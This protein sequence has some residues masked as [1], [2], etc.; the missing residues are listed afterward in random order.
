MVNISRKIVVSGLVQG[1]WFRSFVVDSARNLSIKGW[2]RN[3][4]DGQVELL[5]RGSPENVDLLEQALWIGSPLSQVSDVHSRQSKQTPIL[6]GF[7][8]IW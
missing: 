6:N 3:T 8:I 1:V 5:A 7:K 4:D 2:V